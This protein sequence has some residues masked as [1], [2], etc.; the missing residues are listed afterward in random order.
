VP[1]E[2]TLFQRSR[3]LSRSDIEAIVAEYYP[4]IHRVAYALS[5]REDVGRG[6]IRFVITRAIIQISRW[7]NIDAAKQWFYHFTVLTARRNTH[8]P[9]AEQDCLV[10][11]SLSNTKIQPAYLAFI[12]GLR[13]L[14]FQQR[15]AFI[16]HHGENLALRD[17]AIGM[18]CSTQAAQQHLEIAIDSLQALAGDAFPE[19][20]GR[21]K[22]AYEKLLPA[23]DAITHSLRIII[24]RSLLSGWIKE[25]IKAF[26]TLLVLI[27]TLYFLWRRFK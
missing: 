10:T 4:T 3:K 16:L 12:R 5:G 26:F 1:V 23:E 15:E 22:S 21:F 13:M 7:R 6:I 18:D 17:L 11:S 24:S 25:S 27:L 8:Q 14:P 19:M 9:S 2:P 20:L